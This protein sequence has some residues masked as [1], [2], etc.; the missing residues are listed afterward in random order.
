[1]GYVVFEIAFRPTN[2][3]SSSVFDGR[4]GGLAKDCGGTE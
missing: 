3:Q 4:D 1:M 2:R